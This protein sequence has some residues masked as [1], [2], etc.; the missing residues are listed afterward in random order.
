M[1]IFV[2]LL[3]GALAFL[4]LL[5]WGVTNAL[6]ARNHI[7][8]ANA[9]E[10]AAKIDGIITDRATEIFN[11]YWAIK[12]RQTTGGE[13]TERT[14]TVLDDAEE[15]KREARRQGLV[16][17]DP[18]DDGGGFGSLGDQPIPNVE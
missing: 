7:R 13:E 10:V 6:T 15:A 16:A 12:N 1:T 17:S 11:R 9:L 4:A 18:G 3:F 5:G 2:T 8:E 14:T